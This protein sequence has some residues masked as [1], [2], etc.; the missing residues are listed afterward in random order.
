MNF[1]RVH[2]GDYAAQEYVD[3]TADNFHEALQQCGIEDELIWSIER[4]D[5]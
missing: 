4:I 5:E 2:Y 3:V 1:Y